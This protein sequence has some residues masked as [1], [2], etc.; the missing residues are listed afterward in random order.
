MIERHRQDRR[1]KLAAA[2]AVLL[3]AVGAVDPGPALG[4]DSR[5][6][7]TISAGFDSFGEKFSI[8]ESDTLDVTNEVRSIVGLTF[9]RHWARGHAFDARNSFGF[10]PSAIRN[11]LRLGLELRAR[12]RDEFSLTNEL[13]IKRFNPGTDFTL[14]S[15]HVQEI[16]RAS[17]RAGLSDDVAVRIRHRSELLSFTDPSR[18]EYSY[19]RHDVGAA[20]E[21]VRNL[22]T[23]VDVS[24]D[25]G[26]RSVPDSSAVNYVNHALG[27]HLLEVIGWRWTIDV[28]A[29][30]ERR[31]YRDPWTRPGYYTFDL[32]GR[33]SARLTPR[34]ELRVRQELE[35]FTYD[36]PGDV[37]FNSLAHRSG[38]GFAWTVVQDL[39]FV[40]EPR[41]AYL[42]A[43]AVSEEYRERSVL[44]AIDWIRI[45]RLWLTASVDIG[46]RDYRV[47]GDENLIFS[48]Y[49]FVRTDAFST[50]EFGGRYAWNV[51]LSY[52]P[53]RHD[54]TNDDTTMTLLSTDLTVRF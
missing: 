48:D 25:I 2:V 9:R 54:N 27:G 43:A 40:V 7:T 26:Y 11:A 29:S 22:D 23:S 6:E 42:E 1:A 24:Y 17:Y 30:M 35:S 38:I 46:Q 8:D 20:L 36:I 32:R 47:D 39:E 10:S 14:S 37:Y 34:T 49:S 33:L 50:I 52:E 19:R 28:G 15:N 3:S 51:F 16:V 44:L 5:L 12:R 4:A 31:R 13:T 18:F 45:H 53:E 21:L 41:F